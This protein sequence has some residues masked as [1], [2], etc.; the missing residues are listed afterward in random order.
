MEKEKK[1]K[2]KVVDRRQVLLKPTYIDDL[3]PDDH[4]AR[5][6]WEFVSRL[7]LSDF[8][9]G[10]ESEEGE[11]GRPAFDPRL[12]IALW[13]YAYSEGICSGRELARRLERDNVFQWLSGCMEINYH[14]LCDFRVRFK[15]ELDELFT[16]VLGVL[17]AEGLIS[18][19]V[20]GGDGT[21]I[22]ANAGSNSFHRENRIREHLE[23]ARKQV[24][25]VTAGILG[26]GEDS[27]KR[28]ESAR[29]RAAVE[30]KERLERALKELEK[31]KRE[32]RDKSKEV[33]VSTTDPDSRIMKDGKGGFSPSYNVEFAT[34]GED[35][36]I[37]GCDVTQSGNDCNAAIPMVEQVKRRL[38]RY[39]LMYVE[40]GGF[41]TKENII[42]MER[43]GIEFIS[44][45]GKEGRVQRV[46]QFERR[47]VKEG[48]YG[49]AFRY[50]G[51]KGV[52]TCPAGKV[53]FY[54]GKE[55]RPGV[56]RY[57]YRARKEDCERCE[58]K[59]ECCPGSKNGRNVVRIEYHPAILNFKKKME[60]EEYKEIYKRRGSICEFT[61]ACIKAR[62]K[63]RQFSLRGLIKVWMEVLWAALS[64]NIRRW[65]S[66]IWKPSLQHEGV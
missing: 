32:K 3:I 6:I 34:D 5:G 64:H 29:R 25:E 17:S 8:Y 51:E 21:K 7:D 20:V 43:R 41:L 38:G 42:E 18:L 49:E 58:Y 22:G 62:I 19:K 61:N 52:M 53:L 27:G 9:E 48:F 66:L 40:D 16:Q 60:K 11:A 12:L 65:V 39:P 10:I 13:V 46:K 50:D 63:L 59:S 2:I 57:E 44:S 14:T 54:R 33:R 47:G 1:P 37:V 45:I 28:R 30:R 36:I 35:G 31:M 24:E 26:S 4:P 55:E 23:L 56:M 15:K